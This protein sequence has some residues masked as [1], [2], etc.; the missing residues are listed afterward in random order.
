MRPH[1]FTLRARQTKTRP[2]GREI[3]P[4]DTNQWYP[5]RVHDP[6]DPDFNVPL[7]PIP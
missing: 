4:N 3:C 6:Q 1:E 2:L 7:L 5:H